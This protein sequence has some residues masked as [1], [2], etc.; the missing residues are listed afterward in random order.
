M[1]IAYVTVRFGKKKSC[2]TR[3]IWQGARGMEGLS[4]AHYVKQHASV[5]ADGGVNIVGEYL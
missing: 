2:V 4:D 1:S 3:L 5:L